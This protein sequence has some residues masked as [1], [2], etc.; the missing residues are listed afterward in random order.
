MSESSTAE[1]VLWQVK[2]AD[3]NEH[4]ERQG[5]TL[6]DLS[7]ADI[8]FLEDQLAAAFGEWDEFAASAV[9]DLA[10]SKSSSR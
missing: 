6:D 5:L 10:A 7:E 9:A 8:L 3:L 4:L 2:L 1:R